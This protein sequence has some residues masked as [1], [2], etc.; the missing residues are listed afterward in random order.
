VQAEQIAFRLRK[1]RRFLGAQHTDMID[2]LQTKQVV[3]GE[4]DAPGL[5]GVHSLADVLDPKADGRVLGSCPFRLREECE[6]RA[7]AAIDDLS[8]RLLRARRKGQ[9]RLVEA[10]RADDVPPLKPR[11]QTAR[12]GRHIVAGYSVYLTH[13]RQ[14]DH[15]I[16]LIRATK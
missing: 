13:G 6:L 16:G 7:A 4:S 2:R 5:K 3:V 10:T 9:L 15:A 11:L 12:A 1:P 14:A 8:I